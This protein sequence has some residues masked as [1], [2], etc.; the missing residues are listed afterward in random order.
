MT[1]TRRT[2]V[3]TAALE[4]HR[5][6]HI[7]MS[8]HFLKLL[9]GEDSVEPKR[10]K[11]KLNFLKKDNIINRAE[12]EKDLNLFLTR[13][14]CENT[15]T[16]D[17][18]VTD[19]EQFHKLESFDKMKETLIKA[20]ECLKIH[21]RKTLSNSLYFGKWLEHAQIWFKSEKRTITW[22][23][24]LS[25]ELNISYSQANKLIEIGYLFFHYPKFHRLGISIDELYLKRKQITKYFLESQTFKHYWRGE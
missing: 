17:F 5:D 23:D 9:R 12:E 2:A 25:L 14:L 18:T 11:R 24:F 8:E 10:P 22:K 6:Y 16:Q 7:L 1:E 4:E 15:E 13:R 21:K 19:Y 20:S 3:E